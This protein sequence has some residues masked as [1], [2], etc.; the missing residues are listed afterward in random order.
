M[1]EQEQLTAKQTAEHAQKLE[2]AVIQKFIDEHL[3]FEDD[4]GE[5]Q[6]EVYQALVRLAE[7]YKRLGRR[8]AYKQMLSYAGITPKTAGVAEHLVH[9]E[10]DQLERLGVK[11]VHPE[12]AND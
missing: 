11:F 9:Q 2:A 7:V 8:E 5:E 4:G 12:I 3:E 1:D 10:M 6:T